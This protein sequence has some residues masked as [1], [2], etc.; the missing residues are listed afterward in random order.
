MNIK[1]LKGN[2]NRCVCVMVRCQKI[3]ECEGDPAT[4]WGRG[5]RGGRKIEGVENTSDIMLG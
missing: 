1:I 4:G 3:I 2:D 5:K